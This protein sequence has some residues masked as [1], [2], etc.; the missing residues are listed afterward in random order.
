MYRLLFNMVDKS[1]RTAVIFSWIACIVFLLMFIGIIYIVGTPSSR[2]INNTPIVNSFTKDPMI[3][4]KWKIEYNRNN[5]FKTSDITIV[6]ILDIRNGYVKF[7]YYDG[8]TRPMLIGQTNSESIRWFTR[9]YE[10]IE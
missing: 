7:E 8:T 5:P 9:N 6:K 10:L 1:S 3:G 4:Q 2:I